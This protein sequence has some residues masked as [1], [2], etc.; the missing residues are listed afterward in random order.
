MD[1][2]TQTEL[3]AAHPRI[4]ADP[5]TLSPASRREQAAAATT[6]DTLMQ[7][8]ALNRAYEDRFGFPFV[9]F[10]AGRSRQAM[11]GVLEARLAGSAEAERHAGCL[12]LVAIAH[13][14]LARLQRGER[15]PPT[16]QR[17]QEPSGLSQLPS[18]V[19]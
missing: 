7:L 3:L 12:A 16:P 2:H 14:R 8:E 1:A 6:A 11:V 10:V 19:L 4:G 18:E 17:P 9:E 15:R 13:D 5:A